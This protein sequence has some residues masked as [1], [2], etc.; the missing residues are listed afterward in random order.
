L[1]LLAENGIRFC[2]IRIAHQQ[3]ASSNKAA[4][5]YVCA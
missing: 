3:S 5:N 2:D 4:H 1:E